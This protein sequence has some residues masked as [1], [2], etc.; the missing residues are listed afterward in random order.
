MESDSDMTISDRENAGESEDWE[1]EGS[2]D[3]EAESSEE[4]EDWEV[5]SS[6]EEDEDLD[7][8]NSEEEEEEEEEKEEERA[9]G[10][11]KVEGNDR[12]SELPDAIVEDILSYMPMMDAIK[13]SI[14]SE[15]WRWS[16]KLHKFVLRSDYTTFL[17]PTI[18][19]CLH[20][21]VLK[22]VEEL[23]L[24]FD[25]YQLPSLYLLPPEIYSCGSMKKLSSTL[26]QIFP[27]ATVNWRTLRD[28]SI[29]NAFLNDH[30][31]QMLLVG[32]PRLE[33]L[34]LRNCGG[35][36]HI[37]STTLRRLVIEYYGNDP[38]PT[39]WLEIDAPNLHSLELIG[40][41]RIKL[42]S[43]R[44]LLS[45]LVHVTLTFSLDDVINPVTT[46]DNNV[47]DVYQDMVSR[48]LNKIRH[49]KYLTVGTWPIQTLSTLELQKFP[50]SIILLC[51]H[52]TLD[53]N[54][55]AKGFPGINRLLRSSPNL[56]KL[57][58]D[59]SGFHEY[60]EYEG[61]PRHIWN[62]N[63]K[64]YW[65]SKKLLSHCLKTVE[66]IGFTHNVLEI[67]KFL[68]QHAQGL[69]AMIF[70]K[71]KGNNRQRYFGQG[72]DF[73]GIIKKLLSFP[74]SS[75]HAKILIE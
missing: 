13:T 7:V 9:K 29:A 57:V 20:Q 27:T 53:I 12:I 31:I 70:R 74:R 63:A 14:L 2:E 72:D 22:H 36:N 68:L 37:N 44:N 62:F 5:E 35:Y 64:N 51:K 49:A 15:R 66:I 40:C 39:T 46:I 75:P 28:L 8:E 17:T 58:A 50:P 23:C 19:S 6:E 45:A 21:L 48:L 11:E 18:N 56:E 69:E 71:S 25:S 32:S 16:R 30:V 24:D 33:S 42:Q 3:W 1:L 60:E 52:L 73:F 61:G 10:K 54:L 38:D 4:E 43:L 67:A 26:C 59:L 65:E 47:A 34:L 55:C 41:M